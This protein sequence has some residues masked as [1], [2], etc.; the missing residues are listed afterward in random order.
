MDDLYAITARELE[1]IEWDSQ[2]VN[3]LLEQRLKAHG[4]AF[5]AHKQGIREYAEKLAALFRAEHL[6]RV[7]Q[8]STY[9]DVGYETQPP[10]GL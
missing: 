10:D 7:A 1:S 5:E 8:K 4:E 9:P 3:D 2:D 6:L